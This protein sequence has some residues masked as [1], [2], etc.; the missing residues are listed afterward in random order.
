VLDLQ[1]LEIGQVVEVVELGLAWVPRGH[2]Q[3]LVVGAL[4]VGHAEHADR[5]AEDQAAGK[6]RFEHQDERVERVAVL[7][8]GVRYE[9]VVGRVLRRGEQ[10]PVQADQAAFVVDLVLVPAAPRDLD[11]YVEFHGYQY[12]VFRPTSTESPS[13]GME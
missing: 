6:R 5:A 7:A 1:P 2:A 11:H 3:H 9:A 10:R 4:L 8:Q 13:I 12:S